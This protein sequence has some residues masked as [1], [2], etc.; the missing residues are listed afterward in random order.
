MRN[1]DS[2]YRSTVGF[3]RLFDMLDTSSRPDWPP[4]NIEKKADNDY[5]ITM[6][7]AGFGPGEVELSQHGPE[8]IVS[9][10]KAP[11][12]EERQFLHKGLAIRNFQQAF[13]L[14]DYMN[15]VGATLDNGMLAIDI[16]R[17]VPEQMKPRRIS[18]ASPEPAS[19]AQDRER[20]RKAA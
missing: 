5:R 12:A 7:I 2:L 9:G 8:L 13:R 19:L 17:E 6:A 16:V 14:A 11:D 15:V 20:P 1:F 18:I 3:D 10:Q 4:Y